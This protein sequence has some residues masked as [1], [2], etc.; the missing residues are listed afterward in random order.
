[1]LR[2]KADSHILERLARHSRLWLV[3][4]QTPPPPSEVDSSTERWW[5]EHAAFL[6]E[7]WFGDVRVM[8]LVPVLEESSSYRGPVAI[9]G[10]TVELLR[11]PVTYKGG[12]VLVT[13][14]WRTWRPL[15]QDLQVFVQLLSPDWQ[16]GTVVIDRYALPLP[17]TGGP[18]RLIAG[19]YDPATGKR[20]PVAGGGDFA[21]LGLVSTR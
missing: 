16:P 21:D 5:V 6:D 17:S 1:M 12:M 2:G 11:A 18:L 20:L 8:R 9:L 14:P 15:Q 3:L 10:D 13:L 7:H 19:L 4:P